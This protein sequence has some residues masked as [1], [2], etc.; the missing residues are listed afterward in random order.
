MNTCDITDIIINYLSVQGF[1]RAV[2][3]GEKFKGVFI[4]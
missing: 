2:A 4:L 3:I 1:D